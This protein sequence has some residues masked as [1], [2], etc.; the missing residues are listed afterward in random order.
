MFSIENFPVTFYSLVDVFNF[1][2]SVP[3][4][5]LYRFSEQMIY[6]NSIPVMWILLRYQDGITYVSYKDYSSA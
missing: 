3:E 1:L 5:F 4:S 6:Y 2:L